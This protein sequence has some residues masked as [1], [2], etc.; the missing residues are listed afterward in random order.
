MNRQ[1]G[2]KLIDFLQSTQNFAAMV[3]N[4]TPTV[5]PQSKDLREAA[6]S[7]I[8][9][10]N[11]ASSTMNNKTFRNAIAAQCGM[12]ESFEDWIKQGNDAIDDP[13]GNIIPSRVK[14]NHD[15]YDKLPF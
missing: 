5:E 13:G 7:L 4:M 3:G 15:Q 2:N 12:P 10:I 11:E 1:I 6:T 9:A 8:D 14:S